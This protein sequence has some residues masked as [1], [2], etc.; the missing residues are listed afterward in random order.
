MA[1]RWNRPTLPATCSLPAQGTPALGDIVVYRPPGYGDAKVVHQ[2]VGGD[3]V[4]GWVMQGTNNDFVDQWTPTNDQ[5]VGIVQVHFPSLGGVGVVLLS[6][7]VWA[8]ILVIALGLLLW[9]EKD[10]RRRRGSRTGPG[11]RLSPGWRR[12]DEAALWDAEAVGD[13][14]LRLRRALRDRPRD[15]GRRATQ[16]EQRWRRAGQREPLHE[17]PHHRGDRDQRI[18]AIT[19]RYS[20]TLS[21]V[22][23]ACA[24]LP[25]SV[26]LYRSNGSSEA[27]GTGTV[28]VGRRDLRHH[29]HRVPQEPRER[30]RA[31]DRYVGSADDVVANAGR[32][33]RDHMHRAHVVD[34]GMATA[35]HL[36]HPDG[37]NV[38]GRDFQLRRVGISALELQLHL[39]RDG[40]GRTGS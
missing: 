24:D 14:R 29:D 6:P 39:H 25:V 33:S 36:W 5:V 12:D 7:L 40:R 18:P 22:S 32:R 8:A 30:R 13:H 3:G 38:H 15:R 34:R 28:P 16:R 11:V 26:V 9:P 37:G 2:I 20:V 19:L 31:P 4:N 10:E 35:R 17:R 23:A 21:S 27:T 1:S